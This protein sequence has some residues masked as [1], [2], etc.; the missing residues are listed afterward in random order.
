M[1]KTENSLKSFEMLLNPTK[2]YASIRHRQMSYKERK[3]EKKEVGSAAPCPEENQRKKQGDAKGQK[4][5]GAAYAVHRF[6]IKIRAKDPFKH[7]AAV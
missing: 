7:S 6:G 3:K 2:V 5:N 1:K 4:R